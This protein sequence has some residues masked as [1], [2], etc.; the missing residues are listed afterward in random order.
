MSAKEV[1]LTHKYWYIGS[2]HMIKHLNKYIY[3]GHNCARIKITKNGKQILYNEV[4][5]CQ[6]VI[7]LTTWSMLEAIWL[8]NPKEKPL[9][10]A[11]AI[12]LKGQYQPVNMDQA[13][14]DLVNIGQKGSTHEAFF[15]H[16][17]VLKRKKTDELVNYYYYW[18][19]PKHYRWI[20][21]DSKWQHLLWRTKCIGQI[22]T[23][24]PAQIVL[25]VNAAIPCWQRDQL[26]RLTH[27]EWST[28]CDI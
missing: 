5:T 8:W 26:W 6:N 13:K 3:K 2:S 17:T 1:Q 18:Q 10:T 11:L 15:R 24:R 27:C 12:Y 22:H 9:C 14:E 28:S 23:S 4:E 16:N 19:I 7:H 21:K 25:S 20:G